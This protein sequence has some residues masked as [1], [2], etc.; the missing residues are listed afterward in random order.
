VTGINNFSNTGTIT[1][2]DEFLQP[3][4]GAD[5][6]TTLTDDNANAFVFLQDGHRLANDNT[7]WVG[8]GWI[9]LNGETSTA[10]TQDW[11]FTATLVPTPGA[12]SLLGLA[13]L[14]GVRRRR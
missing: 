14:V 12:A 11:L 8:R 13:A 5:Q 3:M 9:A 2:L 10:G 6:L 1:P 4:G 7:S